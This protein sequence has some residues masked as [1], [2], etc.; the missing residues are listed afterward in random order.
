MNHWKNKEQVLF[1]IQRKTSNYQEAKVISKEIDLLLGFNCHEIE[2]TLI[3]N[4]AK[5][6][7][8]GLDI[9]IFQTPYSEILDMLQFIKPNKNDHWIDFGAAYGRMGIVIGLYYPQMKF[10]GFEINQARVDEGNRIFDQWQL[11]NSNLYC[12]DISNQDFKIESANVFFIYDFGTR[13]DIY[14]LLEKL[15]EKARHQSIKVITRGRGCRQWI[16]LD[17]PWLASINE[18]I[19]F[20]HW[21]IFTS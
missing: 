7:W 8:I 2:K 1:E 3:Q 15:K 9:Q 16:M 6:E 14:I 4:E 21:S 10:T 13:D 17:F 5:Q 18:P 12:Q 20:E 19:H 11:K